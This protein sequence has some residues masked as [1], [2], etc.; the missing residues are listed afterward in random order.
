MYGA[1]YVSVGLYVCMCMCIYRPI[2]VFICMCMYVRVSVQWRIQGWFVGFGRTP[3]LS[4]AE[5]DQSCIK[6]NYLYCLLL[7][8]K[9][10]VVPL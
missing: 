5:V 4:D 9:I 8:Q 10:Y 1:L 2:Y 7:H 6:A 3:P